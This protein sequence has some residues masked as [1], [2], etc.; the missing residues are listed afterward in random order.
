[1]AAAIEGHLFG[2]LQHGDFTSAN[3]RLYGQIPLAAKNKH[4][5]VRRAYAD[6][7][8]KLLE[9]A[10]ASG[11]FRADVNLAVLRL[12]LIGALNWTVEW[13]NPQRGTFKSFVQQIT[14]IVFD[15]MVS[16]EPVAAPRLSRKLRKEQGA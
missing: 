11:E 13:Y 4:R 6:Y 7:W 16:R 8:D 15:G 2:L 14:S 9:Q 12:F 1:M 10:M 5:I 3:I